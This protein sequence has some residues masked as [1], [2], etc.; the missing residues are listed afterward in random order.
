GRGHEA[1]VIGLEEQYRQEG[2]SVLI[3]RGKLISGQWRCGACNARLCTG[4]TACLIAAFPRWIAE[5]LGDY[6]F[7][8]AYA[9]RYFNVVEVATAVYG[10]AEPGGTLS[11]SGHPRNK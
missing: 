10:A 5:S 6:E 3:L 2:E 8:A 11:L 4:A 9:S 7:E 1:C